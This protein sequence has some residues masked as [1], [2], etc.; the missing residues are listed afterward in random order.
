VSILTSLLSER[1]QIIMSDETLFSTGVEICDLS[2]FVESDVF[3]RKV[4]KFF[5]LTRNNPL[6]FLR[7]VLLSHCLHKRLENFSYAMYTY[8]KRHTFSD[9]SIH[10]TGCI[11]STSLSLILG[12]LLPNLAIRQVPKERYVRLQ[13]FC[14]DATEGLTDNEI[15]AFNRFRGIKTAFNSIRFGDL[16]GIFDFCGYETRNKRLRQ[17]EGIQNY[18]CIPLNSIDFEICLPLIQ[19]HLEL[20]QIQQNVYPQEQ[21]NV[22]K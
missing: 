15:N 2:I 4:N 22:I 7:V 5:D 20:L 14:N 12:D 3:V 17:I 13:S 21:N 9:G 11:A 1:T 8:G 6:P 19:R 18:F 10:Y 16:E